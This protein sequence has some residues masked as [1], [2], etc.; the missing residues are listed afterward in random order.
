M[1]TSLFDPS[2]NP[3]G[4][5]VPAN[6]GSA[7]R[8]MAASAAQ[9]GGMPFLKLR[10]QDGKFVYGA[11]DTEIG[12]DD[13]WAVNFNS[14]KIGKIG[15]KG[16]QVVGEMMFPIAHPETIK[17]EDLEPIVSNN[18]SDGWKDQITVELTRLSDNTEVLFKTTSYG[19]KQML[20]NLMGVIG[21]QLEEN[22]AAPIVVVR[23]YSD[24][25]KHPTYGLTFNPLFEVL[26]W[27]D[28]NGQE[29]SIEPKKLV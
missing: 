26:R 8:T 14:F 4:M 12:A 29:P 20:G 24:S 2:N 9:Q 27:L 3:T 22:P 1:S 18:P 25:Y 6:L 21:A 13:Q 15:W 5:S 28:A 11:E 7:L 23:L 17:E 10:K 16:G 19:G